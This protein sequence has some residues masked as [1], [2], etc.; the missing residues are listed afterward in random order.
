MAELNDAT[1]TGLETLAKHT[2]VDKKEI[3]KDLT[4]VQQSVTGV[5]GSVGASAFSLLAD[6]IRAS[7]DEAPETSAARGGD[8]TRSKP[9]VSFDMFFEEHIGQ[10]HFDALRLLSSTA[11]S[12]AAIAADQMTGAERTDVLKQLAKV[13]KKLSIDDEVEDEDEDDEP[14][15]MFKKMMAALE[16]LG[17]ADRI[18][19]KKLDKAYAAASEWLDQARSTDNDTGDSA[20]ATP[21]GEE[22]VTQNALRHREAISYFAL[23]VSAYVEILR[24]IAELVILEGS[25]SSNVKASVKKAPALHTASLALT[26]IIA[27]F[28]DSSAELIDDAKEDGNELTTS[29]Y[30]EQT[31]ATTRVQECLHMLEPVFHLALVS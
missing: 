23:M 6:Q 26:N 9:V 13:K 22:E 31:T 16:K 1:R 28:A 30:M 2:N 12:R 15:E 25:E 4:T 17:P 3:I 20:E 24:K 29:L 19:S 14:A 8:D 11:D 27:W 18:P 7:R 5:L 10:P 21:D